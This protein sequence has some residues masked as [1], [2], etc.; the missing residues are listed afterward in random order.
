[1][2]K[3]EQLDQFLDAF[4]ENR[5]VVW[6]MDPDLNE[7]MDKEA[8]S[9]DQD[10]EA[11]KMHIT[12]VQKAALSKRTLL[13]VIIVVLCIPLICW[14]GFTYM[15]GRHYLLISL[16]I[17]LGSMIP[18]FLIF[19]GRKPK[20]RE[21]MVMAVLIAI[22]VAGR[23]A[24]YMVPSFKPVA[25]ITIIAA[26]SFG[27]ESGFLVGAL[28][29][30]ASN[31][32]F[33]QG[34]WTP[35]QMFSMG[36]IGLIAGLLYAKGLL[37]EKKIPLCVFGFLITVVLYGGIMNTEHFLM[38]SSRLTWKGLLA[39]YLSGLPVDSVHGASTAIFLALASRSMLEKL[40]RIKVKYGL[41]K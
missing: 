16:V 36:L 34:P 2:T 18:F 21:I 6:E 13:S 9:W 10:A 1:M 22:A 38:I 25:A 8:F 7:D 29:M 32:F 19:E 4:L 11:S 33:G 37:S 30:L 35:W 27:A 39:V 12:Q 15:Q 3:Q 41:I 17:A 31:M 40:E 14:M 24:F 20:T 28:S 5:T 23:A 26:M